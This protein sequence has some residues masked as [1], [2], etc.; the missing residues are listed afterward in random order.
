MIISFV[1]DNFKFDTWLFYLIQFFISF[2]SFYY[3]KHYDIVLL[4][5]SYRYLLVRIQNAENR[6][7]TF[8]NEI[9]K[10][11]SRR[12]SWLIIISNLHG[13]GYQYAAYFRDAN[14][15]E[16]MKILW[17]NVPIASPRHVWVAR[18]PI[19]FRPLWKSR[20]RS[21]LYK[22]SVP[23][24]YCITNEVFYT[25]AAIHSISNSIHSWRNK[26]FL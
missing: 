1:N 16:I 11:S 14:K 22:S 13:I 12:I 10:S 20:D 9:A 21:Y 3:L 24:M 26:I 7:M 25:I 17:C 5:V 4:Y 8:H 23:I 6:R 2:F 15:Y 18:R 19:N